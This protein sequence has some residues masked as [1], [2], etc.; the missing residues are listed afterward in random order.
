VYEYSH[1]V[2]SIITNAGFSVVGKLTGHGVGNKVH[3][4]PHIY[5][6]PNPEMKKVFFEP[7]MVLAIE[8]ITAVE[9]TDFKH[10][11]G[12]DRNIYC[13]KGDL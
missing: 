9:S 10:K 11:P 6:T 1:R 4:K 5:N 12:N 8:P 3:E 2:H 7:G 13:N